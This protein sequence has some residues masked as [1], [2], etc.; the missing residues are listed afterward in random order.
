MK[1]LF[2]ILVPGSL[3]I[4]AN[5][6]NASEAVKNPSFPVNSLDAEEPVMAS[7]VSSSPSNVLVPV[8][9]L[10]DSW[11]IVEPPP[12]TKKVV[13]SNKKTAQSNQKISR[14][15]KKVAQSDKEVE[16][17]P[18]PE[19]PP[20][21][22][23]ESIDSQ[24][25]TEPG[26]QA[27]PAAPPVIA[28][29]Q[30]PTNSSDPRYLAA[31]RVLKSNE[32][33]PFS[34]LIPINEIF[35]NHLSNYDVTM[36]LRLGNSR[37]T[38]VGFNATKMFSPYIE[39]STTKDRV[40]RSEYNNTYVQARTVRQSRNFSIVATDTQATAR[41]DQVFVPSVGVGRVRQV[42]VSNGEQS[43]I[44]RTVRGLNYSFSDRN[45]LLNSGFQ[46]LTELLPNS[47]PSLSPAKTQK[48][49]NVN[50]N[51]M[52]AANN[53]RLPQD[54]LTAYNAG[55]GYAANTD[56]LKKPSP[57]ANYN[58]LWFG[59]SPL[60]ERAVPENTA[61][62]F[63]LR[64]TTDYY[65]HVSFTGNT[66]TV[67]SVFRYY[68]GAIFNTGL[69]PEA[70][71]IK[72]IDSQ[73]YAGV[74]FSSANSSGFGYNAS[75]IGYTNPNPENYTRASANINQRINLGNSP[76]NNLTLG[77][78]ANYAFDGARIIDN[79]LFRPG[80]SYL[81]TSAAL[82]LGNITLGTAYY[83]P[84]VL[85]TSSDPINQLLSTSVAWRPSDNVSFSAY[86]NLIDENQSRSPYGANASLRVGQDPNSPT[87]N[88]EWKRTAN[89]INNQVASDNV[90]GLFLRFGDTFAQSK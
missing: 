47:E 7:K 32:V 4:S 35:T 74:D 68:T 16:P 85:P 60:I 29:V 63:R 12:T 6:A 33:A 10:D 57:A 58:S 20:G 37:D 56:D 76:V 53:L 78:G 70:T 21:A 25:A 79:S 90:F 84:G 41:E 2:Y 5:Y 80:K 65:P 71:S 24:P 89:T 88:L 75:L 3:F 49:L 27:A 14:D 87:L 64:E 1:K 54:S 15:G 66:T 55:W 30:A 13:R 46:L 31:P 69:M 82:N 83:I 67:D 34:T 23:D 26:S 18:V 22:P 62:I 86:Y 11:G 17:A 59:L 42:L 72:N 45:A 8:K 9:S 44:G 38:T 51:L 77:V 73:A 28:P 50:G 40:Y 43:G 19:A 61:S 36:G 81:N 48:P 52:Q 39:A